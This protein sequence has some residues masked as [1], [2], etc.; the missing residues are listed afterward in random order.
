M[1]QYL[2]MSASPWLTK[3]STNL[4]FFVLIF[5]VIVYAIASGIDLSKGYHTSDQINFQ[6]PSG[7]S[8]S[9]QEIFDGS[10]PHCDILPNYVGTTSGGPW[11]GGEVGGYSVGDAKC[12]G[13]FT[14]SH[15]CSS[16]EI[17]RS[18]I[19]G[20]SSFSTGWYKTGVISK[21]KSG[22][23]FNYIN[24]CSM[25]GSPSGSDYG[26]VWDISNGPSKAQ[27]STSKQ[28]MCCT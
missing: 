2:K 22:G 3:K 13:E 10:N 4:L 12:A 17:L 5:G 14:G 23:N 11:N 26:N 18:M 27:C 25:F 15:M 7:A 8:K 20:I 24:D 16:D 6:L 1:K 28:V 9:L 21:W 19:C